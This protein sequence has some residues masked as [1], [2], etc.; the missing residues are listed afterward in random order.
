M[1]IKTINALKDNIKSIQLKLF[2]FD[3]GEINFEE[4]INKQ[5]FKP[6][7]RLT[8]E[9]NVELLED[10]HFQLLKPKCPHCN[11]TKYIK[12]GFYDSKP[13]FDNGEKVELHL[14][15]Y[16]CKKCGRRYSTKIFGTNNSKK[17]HSENIKKKVRKSKTSRG[18]SLRDMTYDLKNFLGLN[19]SHQT[20]KNWLKLDETYLTRTK[21]R[22]QLKINK[23]SG[24][25][26]VDEQFVNIKGKRHYRLTLHD[27][28]YK[29]AIAEE[30]IKKR[31]KENIMNFI[32]ETTKNQ[33]RISLTTDGLPVYKNIAD[34]LG[35][36]HQSCIFHFM[37]NLHKSIFP[38]LNKRK[39]SVIEKI[40]LCRNLTELKNI[41]RTYDENESLQF[42]ENLLEHSESFNKK[43]KTY[44]HKKLIPNFQ[45][46]TNFTRDNK[47]PRTSNKAEQWYSGSSK[48]QNK[49][50]Y[51]TIEGLL[52]YLGLKMTQNLI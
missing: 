23:L 42:F 8:E 32:D 15:R 35:F 47:I 44:I 36:V 9:R 48:H 2:D 27:T 43:L 46:L 14:Q 1:T 40:E 18:G 19:I 12:S 11:S 33:P 39:Y 20:V 13:T 52:E 3:D 50:K 22:I 7:E 24:Y 41:F 31:N 17:R 16:E 49:K 10:K 6:P 38:E 4:Q 45:R 5:L 30:I 25:Y 37:K 51:Q 21:N 26:V 29:M 34:E 28:H